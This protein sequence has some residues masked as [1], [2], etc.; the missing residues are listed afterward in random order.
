MEGQLK[1]AMTQDA[2]GDSRSAPTSTHIQTS[3]TANRRRA[4]VFSA[5]RLHLDT[6][7]TP[8]DRGMANL[9]DVLNRRDVQRHARGIISGSRLSYVQVPGRP[10]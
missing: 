4:A 10:V 6:F 1:S 9:S 8:Q 2:K 5:A 3:K 7:N